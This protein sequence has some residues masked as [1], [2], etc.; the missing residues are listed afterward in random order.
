MD[1][2]DGFIYMFTIISIPIPLMALIVHQWYWIL[3]GM[4]EMDGMDSTSFPPFAY[5]C[6]SRK[7]IGGT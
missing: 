7:M 6:W 4:D 1:G 3:D 2:M 5:F